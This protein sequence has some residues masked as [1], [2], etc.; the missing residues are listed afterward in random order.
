MENE[1]CKI[2]RFG[3]QIFRP[4]LRFTTEIKQYYNL[5]SFLTSPRGLCFLTASPHHLSL[6][7]GRC[8]FLTWEGDHERGVILK[9]LME[10][11][12]LGNS[13]DTALLLLLWED[14]ILQGVPGSRVNTPLLSVCASS[15]GSWL[16]WSVSLYNQV[17]SRA[18]YPMNKDS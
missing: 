7:K 14:L 16:F 1:D 2:E 4:W 8:L 3:K 15:I 18:L 17:I 6:W 13:L 5:H 11:V 12:N 10:T 9:A